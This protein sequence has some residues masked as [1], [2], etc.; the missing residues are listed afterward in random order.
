MMHL[1]E[2]AEIMH[3]MLQDV[4]GDCRFDGVA[5]DSR[6]VQRGDL[7]VAIDAIGGGGGRDG[8]DFVRDAG[9][10]GAVAAL[11][12]SRI[13]CAIPQIKVPDT[14]AA[15]GTLGANWRARFEK[16]LLAVT[17][18][19][20][21]TTVG[22]LIA[23]IFNAAGRCLSP[24]RSFNNQWGVPLTLLRLRDHHTH[25][26]IEMGMNRR[27]EIAYLS[28]LAKPDV[29]LINNVAPAHL[30]GLTDLE[31]IADAKAEIFSGLSE[32]GVA[33]LNRD[34]DF[35]DHWRRQLN[36]AVLTFGTADDADVRTSDIDVDAHGGRF[37]LHIDAKGGNHAAQNIKVNLPLPGRHNVLNAAAA[38]AV[39]FAAGA[40]I[41]QIKTGL[42]SYRGIDG[43]LH[44]SSGQNGA[45]IIDDSYNANPGSVKA[46]IDVLAA[47]AGTRIAVFGAMAELGA[48]SDALHE[49]VAR[50]AK[51]SGI[52]HLICLAESGA[53]DG[54][55]RGFDGAK[56][57][58]AA[59]KLLAHLVPLLAHDVTVLVKGSRAAGM[60]RIAAALRAPPSS[61]MASTVASTAATAGGT[62][63]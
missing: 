62:S 33:V 50:H 28:A 38:A 19:N 7:F 9:E 26:V 53:I 4:Q 22:G 24:H 52:D 63:C 41:A 47:H 25:A 17:G 54:Y 60:E 27:G 12:S 34:D 10:K 16:P 42:E 1:S 31:G 2:A 46:A 49:Q 40:D 39:A 23:A 11:V 15:L 32:K 59:E 14:T 6:Q 35:Y 36:A 48:Q 37:T 20:G 51:N 8:H 13:D 44:I 58:D 45:R 21:K 3:G 18:S 29:A 55:L 56:V 61:I 57:F 30:A 5:I 43:R